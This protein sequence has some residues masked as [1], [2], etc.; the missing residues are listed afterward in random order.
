MKRLTLLCL[1]ALVTGFSF[2]L[3]GF[4][5][6]RANQP[7]LPPPPPAPAGIPV[8]S[9]P[10]NHGTIAS[11]R[12]GV[13]DYTLPAGQ[14]GDVIIFF[15]DPAHPEETA[16]GVALLTRLGAVVAV[17]DTGAYL[18]ALGA[19]KGECLW[20]SSEVEGLNRD[21]Q[22]KLNF[23][24]F[25]LPVL[26]S[27]G[28]G[29]ALVEALLIEAPSYSFAGGVSAD[30]TPVL[31]VPN[32]LAFCGGP[33]LTAQT[34]G[35]FALGA[36]DMA[37]P[38]NVIPAAGVEQ[39]VED[40]L[41]A[42]KAELMPLSKEGPLANPVAAL[43]DAVKPLL[44]EAASTD[45]SSLKDLPLIEMPANAESGAAQPYIVIV[46]SGDGGW[47]DLDRTLGQVL[48]AN[49]IPV[50]GVDSLLYFWKPKRAE[51]VAHDLDRIIAHY[52]EAWH[53]DK[54]VLV[55]YSFGADILP[56]AY[57]RLDAASQAAVAEVSLLGLSRSA[58]FEISV[59]G[60]FTEVTD[61]ASRAVEPE[62]A[63]LPPNLLQCFYGEDEA[64]ESACTTPAGSKTEV[65]RTPGGHHFGDDY[66]ALAMRIMAGAKTRLGG[67]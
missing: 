57:N 5:S 63:K 16:P 22:H 10:A 50:V 51:V 48:S 9:A 67:K 59:E 8:A 4:V 27:L 44:A 32:K 23:P 58:N 41:A 45:P 64:E 1:L 26:A 43:A 61:D 53:A 33:A 25:R 15:T 14:P 13:V 47:R 49:G 66:D 54:V 65:I 56:F 36:Q 40:W 18:K 11:G 60:Y 31:T 62:L 28:Q 52:R 39:M 3:A 21:L 17:V 29:A 20:L 37:A 30:F 42:D 55:G 38:W 35:S 6:T 46:F 7:P 2:A 24:E 34:D 19:D 12:L